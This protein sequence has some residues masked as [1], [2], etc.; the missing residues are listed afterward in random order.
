MRGCKFVLLIL[1]ALL[2][3]LVRGY[4]VTGHVNG[5]WEQ[6]LKDNDGREVLKKYNP[7]SRFTIS[8]YTLNESPVLDTRIAQLDSDS[9]FSFKNLSEGKY[10]LEIDSHDLELSGNI[11]QVRINNNSIK[12]FKD[13]L[14]YEHADLNEGVNLSKQLLEINAEKIKVYRSKQKGSLMDILLNSPFGFILRSRLYTSIF[15]GCLLLMAA[16]SIIAYVSP[17]LAQEM[18]NAQIEAAEAKK[19]EAITR[20]KEQSNL[21]KNQK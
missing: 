13:N 5:I 15:V 20:K 12:A 3:I 9:K 17:E 7:H 16:P 2:I 6:M 4:E 10:Q 8:L 11:Y 14:R 18:K 21:T 19:K 1:Q